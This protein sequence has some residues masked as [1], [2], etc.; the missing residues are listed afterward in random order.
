MSSRKH[1]EPESDIALRVKAMEQLLTEKGIVDTNAI[2][3][4][5]DY[6][7]NKVGPRN[8]ARVVARGFRLQGAPVGRRLACYRRAGLFRYAG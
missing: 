5:A 7:E 8:G 6:F 4:V 2:D 3:L 1:N